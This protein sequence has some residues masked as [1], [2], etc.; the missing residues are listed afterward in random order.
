MVEF[1]TLY[2]RMSY[3]YCRKK[4]ENVKAIRRGALFDYFVV[5]RY[6]VEVGSRRYYGSFMA[7]SE[8]RVETTWA[9]GSPGTR[10]VGIIACLKT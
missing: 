7:T 2:A 9:S 3:N 1:R 4:P 10:T 8:F 6:N 5:R